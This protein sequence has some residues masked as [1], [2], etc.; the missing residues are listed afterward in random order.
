[1]PKVGLLN[2]HLETWKIIYLVII[3]LYSFQLYIYIFFYQSDMHNILK[4]KR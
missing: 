3:L 2:L 1:M 4:I